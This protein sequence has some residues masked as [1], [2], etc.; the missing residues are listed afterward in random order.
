M[1]TLFGEKTSFFSSHKDSC[2]LKSPRAEAVGLSIPAADSVGPKIADIPRIGSLS[3]IPVA[4]TLNLVMTMPKI[5]NNDLAY[6]FACQFELQIG[7]DFKMDVQY[8][9]YQINQW[10]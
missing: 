5:D 4:M 3:C 2:S 8:G 1:A 9:K 6:K 10:I 7:D